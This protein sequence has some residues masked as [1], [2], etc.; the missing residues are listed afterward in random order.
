MQ[1]LWSLN[2]GVGGKVPAVPM[3]LRELLVCAP[4]ARNKGEGTK[5]HSR[6]SSVPGST[7]VSLAGASE[8]GPSN[9]SDE[10]IPE[11]GLL[12]GGLSQAGFSEDCAGLLA[13]DQL[14]VPDVFFF[15]AGEFGDQSLAPVGR[16]IISGARKIV[17]FTRVLLQVKQLFDARL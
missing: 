17:Q 6:R 1:G 12:S 5:R 16:S 15:A 8:P 14:A 7:W 4:V 13:D 9:T 11:N 3:P 10:T 2:S